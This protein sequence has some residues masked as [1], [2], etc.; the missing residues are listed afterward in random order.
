M[1]VSSPPIPMERKVTHV[2][3]KHL[4]LAHF[5]GRHK[6]T[7]TVLDVAERQNVTASI[8]W[9]VKENNKR[10]LQNTSYGEARTLNEDDKDNTRE[11]I[12]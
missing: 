6:Q 5:V 8:P 2:R 9:W 11:R 10:T 7:D 3:L 1:Q 4:R 12:Q